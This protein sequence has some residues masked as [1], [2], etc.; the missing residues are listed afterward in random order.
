MASIQGKA[1]RMIATGLVGVGLIA[2]AMTRAD[3]Q[4]TKPLPARVGPALMSARSWGYQLQKVDPSALGNEF[5]VLVVDYARDGTQA[6]AYTKADVERFRLRTTGKPRIVLSYLSIGEAESY[7]SYWRPDWFQTPPAWVGAE[8]AAWRKNYAVNFWDARWQRLLFNPN[9][10]GWD[11]AR[12]WLGLETK[13]YLDRIIDAGFDGVYLDRV[14]AYEAVQTTRPS[15]RDDMIG[16]V[17]NLSAFA[18][19]RRPGFLVLPQN[20]EELLDSATYRAAI[21]GVGK[22]DLLFGEG[23]DGVAND[24]RSTRSSVGFLNRAKADGRPVF[25][26]E[27]IADPLVQAKAQT[28]FNTLG[29]VAAF[30]ARSLDQLP[31]SLPVAVKTNGPPLP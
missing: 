9:P 10:T 26:V 5:D 27:Y 31:Q 17:G 18:K 1:G 22:E 23:G 8:N 11:R 15:A 30:A 24:P 7:R 2:V 4:A 14:D 13:P 19:T 29:Y 16:L 21:D 3:A 20:A 12:E 28:D 6:T 25:V